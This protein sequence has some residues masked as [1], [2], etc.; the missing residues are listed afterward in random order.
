[1]KDVLKFLMLL[2][3]RL[4]DMPRFVDEDALHCAIATVQCHVDKAAIWE[5]IPAHYN[6]AFKTTLGDVLYSSH[7][8]AYGKGVR[9]ALRRYA[10]TRVIFDVRADEMELAACTFFSQ[11][12]IP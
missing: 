5:G 1:M 7:R 3:N 10:E 4:L 2:D 8:H 6:F 12:V 9:F 11:R